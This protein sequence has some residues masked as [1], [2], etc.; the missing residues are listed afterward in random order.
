MPDLRL[1]DAQVADVAT[2]L[3]TLTGTDR[4]GSAGDAD[5]GAVRCGAA[6][7]PS[8]PHAT[9]GGAGPHGEDGHDGK[10][11]DLGQRV[12]A[13]YGCFSCHDIKGF[14]TTQPIGVDLSEEGSKLVTRLDFAFVD[15]E[16]SKLEWFHQKLKD[17]RSFDQGRVLEPL[18][19]LRMPDFHFSEVENERL[20]TAIMSFQR[21]VQPA[22]ALP[23]AHREARLHGQGPRARP[24]AELRRVP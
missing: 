1:T 15:I 12:I 9:R 3:T 22:S 23:R 4:D 16:H 18:E 13:R 7:L 5:A 19:K 2:Y 8:Q 6:R 20:Q 21:E 17:P 14:E 11:L 10:Q 24:P